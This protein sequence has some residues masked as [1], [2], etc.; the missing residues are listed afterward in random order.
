[1]GNRGVFDVLYSEFG[2]RS[3]GVGVAHAVDCSKIDTHTHA[4]NS[5]AWHLQCK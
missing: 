4:E 3:C 5:K 2:A 1:M